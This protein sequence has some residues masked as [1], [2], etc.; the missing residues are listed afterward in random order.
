MPP[1]IPSRP[2]RWWK[3]S[4]WRP[5]PR[6][7]LVALTP[8][9]HGDAR[10]FLSETYSLRRFREIGIDIDFVQDNHT[11]SERERH[12]PRPPLPGAPARA[13]QARP[14]PARRD[15]RC[16]RRHPARLARLRPCDR[17]RALR[18]KLAPALCASRLR[19]RLLHAHPGR[20]G[21][22]SDDELLRRRGRPRARLR[23]SRSRDQAGRWS[24]RP[25]SCPTR[26]AATPA[27]ATFPPISASSLC[28]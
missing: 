22:L 20:R 10:G 24:R 13:G 2:G 14:R 9:R 27:S 26:T 7:G 11:F 1:T 25:R 19:P 28:A 5:S 4:W 3:A 17:C 15:R 16:R 8:P 12:H 21:A 18:R 23:R 6:P